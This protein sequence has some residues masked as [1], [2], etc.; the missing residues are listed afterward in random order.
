M[1][2][3]KSHGSGGGNREGMS[4]K[5]EQKERWGERKGQGEEEWGQRYRDT[6]S[7][8]GKR[9]RTTGRI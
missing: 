4:R 1:K 9:Q 5:T 3:T 8:T 7:K 2:K 6:D